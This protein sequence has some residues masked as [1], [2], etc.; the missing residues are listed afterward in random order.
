MIAVTNEKAS[1][2]KHRWL[3]AHGFLF[4]EDRF[5]NSQEGIVLL[6]EHVFQAHRTVKDLQQEVQRSM[7]QSR[8]S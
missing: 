2:S 3:V 6:G 4:F 8:E 7:N 1:G 5:E